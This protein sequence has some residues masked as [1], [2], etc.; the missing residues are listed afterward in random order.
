MENHNVYPQTVSFC[1]HIGNIMS[2]DA[3]HDDL[4]SVQMDPN[5]L[6]LSF[7]HLLIPIHNALIN[8]HNDFS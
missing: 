1:V 8:Q 5:V 6:L 2:N 3:E 7:M 4:D